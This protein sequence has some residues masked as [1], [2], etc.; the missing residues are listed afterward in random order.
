MTLV[1]QIQS[2]AL[3]VASEIRDAIRPRLLPPG[4]TTGQVLQ[5][6]ATT[7]YASGWATPFSGAYSDLMDKPALFSGKYSDLSGL[8]V[9]GT[10][11]AKNLHIGTTAP[12]SPAN[13][14]VWITPGDKI[15]G[16][17]SVSAWPVLVASF[18]G[19]QAITAG[20]FTT[21]KMTASTDTGAGFN[22][23]TS[24]Y[25]IPETGTYEIC[26]KVRMADG[27]PNFSHGV[28]V[29]TANQDSPSFQW[30]NTQSGGSGVNR[31]G[32]MNVITR[33]FNAGDQ[34]RMFTYL[35]QSNSLIA[36]S[37]TMIRVR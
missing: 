9:L 14:D 24:I 23:T 3:R 26:A 11:A 30:G 25:T 1:A 13:G 29:D 15:T 17:D 7:N 35:E 33:P 16:G 32:L 5:K 22:N 6:T 4:G 12:P 10:A 34:V 31:N 18:S 21:V 8:P 36:A 37:L 2:L 20:S 19:S 27:A 28:G